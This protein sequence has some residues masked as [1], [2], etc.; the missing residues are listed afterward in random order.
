MGLSVNTLIIVFT[1]MVLVYCVLGVVLA[2]FNTPCVFGLSASWSYTYTCRN[3][4]LFVIAGGC[5][6]IPVL[7]EF[8]V[9]TGVII[10]ILGLRYGG[11]I[12]HAMATSW[13]Q[14]YAPVR[15]CRLGQAGEVIGVDA[16]TSVSAAELVRRLRTDAHEHYLFLHEYVAQVSELWSTFMLSLSVA[17]LVLVLYALVNTVFLG[18]A[19]IRSTLIVFVFLLVSVSVFAIY[20]FAYAN[21]AVRTIEHALKH[22]SS[23]DDYEI[24]GG[25]D[26]W[27]EYLGASP[28][29]WTIH[30]FAITWS[31]LY[32]FGSSVITSAAGILGA[33]IY[34]TVTA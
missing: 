18:N 15:K 33:I 29:Y 23:A 26:V 32:V 1:A 28:A 9:L 17:T 6:L 27:M 21:S 13:V 30:G 34:K 24:I 2:V 12:I 20:C 19:L 7:F 25:R 22:R 31:S 11:I 10:C 5:N 4:W 8:I 16:S 3:Q 14:R